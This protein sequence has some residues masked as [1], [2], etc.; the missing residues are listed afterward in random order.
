MRAAD[1]TDRCRGHGICV[2]ICPDNVFALTDDGYSE[3]SPGEIPADLAAAV[4]D[5]ARNCPQHAITAS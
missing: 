3:A 4:A 2:V 1:D 5:A